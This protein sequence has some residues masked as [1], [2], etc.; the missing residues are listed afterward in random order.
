MKTHILFDNGIWLIEGYRNQ[1]SGNLSLKITYP[2]GMN[3]EYPCI[4]ED[5]LTYDAPEV[6]PKYIK[7]ECERLCGFKKG[8]KTDAVLSDL[9]GII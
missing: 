3:T 7:K 4:H 5:H 6:L 9:N 2:N 1:N 8:R